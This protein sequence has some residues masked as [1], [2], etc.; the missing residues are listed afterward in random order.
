M[1]WVVI[2]LFL[3]LCAGAAGGAY[4]ALHG[5]SS[6]TSTTKSRGKTGGS[7]PI[8]LARAAVERFDAAWARGADTAAAR[9]T[10]HPKTA[11]SALI[12]SRKGLDGASVSLRIVS[13]RLTAVGAR[14][15][16]EATWQ[17]PGFGPWR[18]TT[19]VPVRQLKSGAWK[20]AWTPRIIYSKLSFDTRL[21]TERNA[22][23]RAP[24]LDRAGREILGDRAVVN[25]GLQRDKVKNVTAS[26]T[27]LARLLGLNAATL[28]GQTKGAG[29]KQFLI[30]VTMRPADFKPIAA[31]LKKIQGAL[32]ITTRLPITPTH[33]FARQLLGAIG[34]AT[35]EQV[36]TSKR[37]LSPGDLVGQWGLEQQYDSH[38]GGTAS[39]HV[40]TRDRVTGD[41]IDT[42][43]THQ[44][45]APVPLRTTISTRVQNAAEQALGTSTAPSAIVVEQPSTGDVLA[46]ANRPTES[47]FDRALAGVY[48]PGSTFK[49]ITTMALLEHGF[50]PSSTVPCP[51]TILVGGRTFHNYQGES[52]GSATFDH[53]FAI[54]C[55]TAFISL[56][57]RLA[58]TSLTKTALE[59]GLGK[60][61]HLPFGTASSHVPLSRDAVS[62]AAM[63]IGQDRI[64]ATPLAM[65]GVAATVA[66]GRWHAPRLL[67]TDPKVVG[68]PL[69]AS[70]LATLRAL[71]RKVVLGGSG[72]ALAST[73]GEPRC[74]TGTA[75]FGSGNPLP[76]HAWFICFRGDL[77]LSVLVEKGQ[78]GGSVAAPIAARFFSAYDRTR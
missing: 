34:S 73:P 8:D 15:M 54:S 39:Y 10:D 4:V 77:A 3:L 38:L 24:I 75:E 20:V 29:P 2:T 37:G 70:D 48:A 5:G 1:R 57:P 12:A 60:N 43:A 78:S 27:A 63:M 50:D 28:I 45:R 49:V 42:L 31:R 52:G 51:A 6:S 53:D 40:I 67:V 14:A 56:A 71:M 33:A 26:A 16:Q 58:A 61:K 44:G 64:V 7:A 18:T 11:A 13:V 32:S 30:A 9:L 22:P 74:K 36:K 69:A 76:T 17:V 47:T 55:N 46:V 68:P 41:A 23:R 21:G 19:A 65:A 35:A 59:F 66:S 62:H 72:T 25:V